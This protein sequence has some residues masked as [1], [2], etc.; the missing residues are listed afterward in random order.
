MGQGGW[1]VKIDAKALWRAVKNATLF[2]KKGGWADAV[3][4]YH[5][6]TGFLRIRTSDD[7]VGIDSRVPFVAD[8]LLFHGTLF[9]SP[10]SLKLLEK[11][12]RDRDEE[13]SIRLNH[14]GDLGDGESV[15][16]FEIGEGDD[17]W[18]TIPMDCPDEGWWSMFDYVMDHTFAFPESRITFEISPDRMTQ[19]SRLEPK[20]EYPIS[21]GHCSVSG[22]N[23]TAFRYGPMTTGMIM[24][25]DRKALEEVYKDKI[26]DVLWPSM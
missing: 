10:E 13:L 3:E 7:Y 6:T 18:F 20:S 23:T 25:L 22:K 2:A 5:D 16:S 24:D 26:G 15:T 9:I 12:L 8:R 4:F 21:F 1:S 17:C 19:L 14:S 11:F